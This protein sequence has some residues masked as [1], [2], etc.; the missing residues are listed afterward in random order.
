MNCQK[1]LE[2]TCWR[3]SPSRLFECPFSPLSERITLVGTVPFPFFFLPFVLSFFFFQC[4]QEKSPNS[5]RVYSVYVQYKNMTEEDMAYGYVTVLTPFIIS[6][7]RLFAVALAAAAVASRC[8]C[9]VLCCV[10]QCTGNNAACRR[11]FWSREKCV[12][13]VTVGRSS[14]IVAPYT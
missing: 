9:V 2:S 8:A 5:P 11:S 3:D 7:S 4:L 13:E 10:V 14:I 6:F 1:R 12:P